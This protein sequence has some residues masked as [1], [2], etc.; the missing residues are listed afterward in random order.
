MTPI[1]ES[2]LSICEEHGASDIH[3]TAGFAP[4]FRVRGMLIEKGDFAP[5]ERKAVDAVA[6]ELG[7]YTLPL[8]SP[9]GIG[10]LYPV[11]TSFAVRKRRVDSRD[12]R[13]YALTVPRRRINKEIMLHLHSSAHS[14]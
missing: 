4:R 7:L 13:V 2:L 11:F 5:F 9:D 1:L 6:M 3:L 10:Q 14:Q 12:Q 8:G